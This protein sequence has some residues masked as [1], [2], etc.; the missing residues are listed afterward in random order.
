MPHVRVNRGNI[1]ARSTVVT[2]SYPPLGSDEAPITS[3]TLQYQNS[4]FS[5]NIGISDG[6]L[7]KQLINLKPYTAYTVRAAA[8]SLLGT[9]NWSS[10]VGFTTSIAGKCW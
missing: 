3:C 10:P 2:W 5:H 7:R 1:Q 4:S 8:K 6:T 9:G